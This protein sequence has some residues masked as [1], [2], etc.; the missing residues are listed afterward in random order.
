MPRPISQRERG[1]KQCNKGVNTGKNSVSRVFYESEES[2]VES[3][4]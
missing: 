1:G 3:I 4:L 2:V